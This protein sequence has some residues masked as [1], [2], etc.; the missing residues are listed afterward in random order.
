MFPWG[1]LFA[2]TLGVEL[3]HHGQ[4][5]WRKQGGNAAQNSDWIFRMVEDHRDQ[6]R[7]YGKVCGRQRGGIRNDPL[8]LRDAALFLKVL[9]IGQGLG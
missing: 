7:G 8:D 6:H 2:W 4:P 3:G 9:Q 1:S 5:A